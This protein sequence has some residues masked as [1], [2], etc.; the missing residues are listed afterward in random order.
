M[1]Y[2][3]PGIDAG[4]LFVRADVCD[5][6]GK[7]QSQLAIRFREVCGF[8]VLSESDVLDFHEEYD[9]SDGWLF[10]IF[11]GG[12]F[13]QES[14]RSGFLRQHAPFYR[15]FLFEDADKFI[16]VLSKSAP[17]IEKI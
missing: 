3:D 7:T 5:A 4:E 17:S 10:E 9:F 11:S 8:R 1:E 14:S 16:S 13:E 15:E 12:W 2:S 6:S